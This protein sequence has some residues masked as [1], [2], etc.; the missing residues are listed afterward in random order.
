[1]D[2]GVEG[3]DGEIDMVPV[4]RGKID[5]VDL[6]GGQQVV[7]LVIAVEVFDAVFFTDLGGLLFMAADE[8]DDLAIAGVLDAG[9]KR[10]LRDPA[11]SD[12]CVANLT[13]VDANC[14]RH[15]SPPAH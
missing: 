13:T 2:A 6:A 4:G 8:R 11:D 1:M 7:V 12:H 15:T 3:A 14:L 10:S 5:S 9:Q